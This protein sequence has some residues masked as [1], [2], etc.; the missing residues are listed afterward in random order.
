MDKDDLEFNNTEK[1]ELVVVQLPRKDVAIIRKIVEE[2]R[3]M[4]LM[5]TKVY[6]FV[7]VGIAGLLTVINFGETI[8]KGIVSFFG[9]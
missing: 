1:D 4:G 8:K 5:K 3:A 6:T 7:F 2:R 9:G